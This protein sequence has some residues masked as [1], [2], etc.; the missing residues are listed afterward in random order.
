[1]W[2]E[3]EKKKKKHTT[4]NKI[5][6]KKHTQNTSTFHNLFPH[7]IDR[8]LLKAFRNV[9]LRQTCLILNLKSILLAQ[10]TAFIFSHVFLVDSV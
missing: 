2:T 6:F 4:H 3:K 7:K 9:V 10:R 8:N 5:I 1:M